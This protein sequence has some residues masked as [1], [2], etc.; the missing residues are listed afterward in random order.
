V[1]VCAAREALR[2][3]LAMRS[4]ENTTPAHCFIIRR[5]SLGVAVIGGGAQIVAVNDAAPNPL[6][7]LVNV[8]SAAKDHAWTTSTFWHLARRAIGMAAVT[9]VR[10][11]KT[12]SH[13]APSG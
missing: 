1:D 5:I 12:V 4:L 8:C 2:H 3:F 10:A 9:A 13:V 6:Q 7:P 11:G